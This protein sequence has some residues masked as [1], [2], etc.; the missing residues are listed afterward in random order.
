MGWDDGLTISVRWFQISDCGSG[1]DK[2]WINVGTDNDIV[3]NCET[4]HTETK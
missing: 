1:N 3:K 4:V 2:A